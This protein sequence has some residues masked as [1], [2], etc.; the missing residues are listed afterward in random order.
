M[1]FDGSCQTSNGLSLNNILRVG[2]TLQ[3][4]IF[5]ILTRF[6]FHKYALVADIVK[7]YRQVLVHDEDCIWQCI[8][9]RKSPQEHLQTYILKTV[10]YGTSCAPY[11]AV[12]SL[13][14]VAKA[15]IFTWITSLLEA[16]LYRRL[17]KSRGK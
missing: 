4:D 3:D 10:T 12:K 5:T 17:L 9:W 14:A 6:R 15:E 2:P 1:G 11:L 13:E 8:S 16:A 7:M